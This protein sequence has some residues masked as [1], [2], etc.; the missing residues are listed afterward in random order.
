MLGAVWVDDLIGYCIYPTGVHMNIVKTLDGGLTWGASVRIQV[1]NPAAAEILGFGIWYQP[2]TLFDAPKHIHIAWVERDLSGGNNHLLRYRKWDTA[3][4]IPVVPIH[5]VHSIGATL[6]GTGGHVS[7][8]VCTALDNSAF[9]VA[10]YSGLPLGV[11]FSAH[12]S[13]NHTIWNRIADWDPI[14]FDNKLSLVPSGEFVDG[15]TLF[16]HHGGGIDALIR[17]NYG[18]QDDSWGGGGAIDQGPREG[19]GFPETV[20]V[21]YNITNQ[22]QLVLNWSEFTGTRTLRMNYLEISGLPFVPPVNIFTDAA[23]DYQAVGIT[24]DPLTQDIFV[25]YIHVANGQLFR[26]VSVDD[27]ASWSA[28]T[29]VNTTD[30]PNNYRL[31]H[32]PQCLQNSLSRIQPFYGQD[33]GG[34]SDVVFNNLVTSLLCPTTAVGPEIQILNGI[35]EIPCGATIEM[36]KFTVNETAHLQV[37]IRNDGD[38]TLALGTI[39][40]TPLISILF[41]SDPSGDNVLPAQITS[42]TVVADTSTVALA[43]TGS[44][45]IPS[46]DAD[47]NPCVVNFLFDVNAVPDP[48]EDFCYRYRCRTPGPGL[49]RDMDG[50]GFQFQ[51]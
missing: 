48:V 5:N 9:I 14:P 19:A 31:I 40:A 51:L 8:S 34:A 32:Q 15:I 35:K 45:S 18:L 37:F 7:V 28:E 47:E 10:W 24:V 11:N 36:G 22:R 29:K 50:F 43:Q 38:A 13:P 33:T 41:G 1:I 42:V 39:T 21:A 46:N 49:R 44:I 17:F 16:D 23:H 27:G 26:R 12:Q 25:F 6:D 3:T 4:D 2:W 30:D 20:R